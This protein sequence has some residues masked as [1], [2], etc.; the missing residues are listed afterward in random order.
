MIQELN[1]ESKKS[2]VDVRNDLRK[3]LDKL[4]VLIQDMIETCDCG[5]DRKYGGCK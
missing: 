1:L 5:V 3:T 4:E 2:L